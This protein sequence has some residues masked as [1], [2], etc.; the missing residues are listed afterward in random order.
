MGPLSWRNALGGPWSCNLLGWALMLVPGA[1]VVA[2]E[3]TS[4]LR[5]TP[6]LLLTV[7]LVSSVAQSLGAGLVTAL[8]ATIARRRWEVIPLTLLIL[9]WLAIGVVRGVIGGM[10]AQVVVGANPQFSER[11]IA[12]I[13]VAVVWMPLFSYTAA[14]IEHRRG[15]LAEL[16]ALRSQ[17]SSEA[18]RARLSSTELQHAILITITNRIRPVIDEL[19]L[20]LAAVSGR[21]DMAAMEVIGEQLA[22]LSHDT[23]L[24]ISGQPEPAPEFCALDD[25]RPARASVAAA[26]A[27]ELRRPV[28]TALLS[29]VAIVPTVISVGLAHENTPTAASALVAL[30]I[31]V[32]VLY[33]T[34]L[35]RRRLIPEPR[36]R[37]GAA[38]I[39]N[40]LVAGLSGSVTLVF[41]DVGGISAVRL[42]LVAVLP[43]ATVASAACMTL[44]IGI[45]LANQD[46]V[47]ALRNEGAVVAEARR[48]SATVDAAV[49]DQLALLMHGPVQGRL[50]AC[51]MALNFHLG[52]EDS[53]DV[54]RTTVVTSAVIEHLAAASRDLEVLAGATPATTDRP[55]DVETSQA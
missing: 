30:A 4:L 47:D 39:A 10:V 53:A 38:A 19:R 35:V 55:V 46:L 49:R 27:V 11:L 41:M 51:V 42:V 2:V 6:G 45:G 48:R 34:A 29:G 23:K 52:S 22:G 16:G 54:H 37:D 44:A 9:M 8:I 24:L 12:W 50:S 31:V 36:F 20:A 13:V 32:V 7:I 28:R 5:V 14:Q 15:L 21:S 43:I 33:L 40:Y 25:S 26:L 1:L 3:E 18:A 17:S